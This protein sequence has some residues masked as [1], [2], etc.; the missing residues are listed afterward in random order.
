MLLLMS[1]RLLSH[2]VS[3][4]SP[5]SALVQCAPPVGR[6]SYPMVQACARPSFLPTAHSVAPFSVLPHPP[7]HHTLSR[8]LLSLG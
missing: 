5:L 7:P 8:H 1:H 6:D 3:P 4:L 2:H